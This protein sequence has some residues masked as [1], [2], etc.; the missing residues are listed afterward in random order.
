M[1]P[2]LISLTV[3][4]RVHAVAVMPNVTLLRLL[5]EQLGYTDVKNGCEKGDCGACTVL[6]DDEPVNSCLVFAWQA[7]GGNIITA[8]G[9]VK[10]GQPHPI[11]EAFADSGAVQCGYCTPG[12]VIST[13]AL[14]DK[15][16][17]PSEDEIRDAISGNLCRCTGY[18]LIVKAV[19][20]AAERMSVTGD[21][22]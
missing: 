21:E 3:N 11:Q 19:Q 16:P 6:L 20:M 14:L 9:L 15:N 1:K 17:H 22:Q 2:I 18:G 7:D 8:A 13:K 10:N 5:R 12:L 4:G